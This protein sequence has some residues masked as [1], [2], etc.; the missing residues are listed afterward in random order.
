MHVVSIFVFIVLKD[1][2]LIFLC[3]SNLTSCMW[4]LR[5]QILPPSLFLSLSL[6][7]NKVEFCSYGSYRVNCC[8]VTNLESPEFST[9]WVR[10]SCQPAVKLICD[11]YLFSFFN[12]YR[13]FFDNL[14]SKFCRLLYWN[15]PYGWF[16]SA[17]KPVAYPL[18]LKMQRW[19]HP[20][21]IYLSLISLPTH[22]TGL[23]DY[24]KILGL[25]FNLFTY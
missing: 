23:G 11:V 7:T 17:H 18:L 6:I 22:F 5:K 12:E 19:T 9:I 25:F 21:F 16:Q 2:F 4:V 1:N 20:S 24:S 13:K 10:L 15:Q 3:R 8:S 14:N